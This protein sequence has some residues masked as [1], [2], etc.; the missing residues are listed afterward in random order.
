MPGH[1]FVHHLVR[2]AV[3]ARPSKQRSG[4]A[5]TGAVLLRTVI[6]CTDIA[7]QASLMGSDNHDI[8]V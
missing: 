1:G 8:G 3:D 2:S 5:C 4:A 7:V 6:M